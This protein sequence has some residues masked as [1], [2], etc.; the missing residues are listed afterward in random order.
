MN[1]Q[2][3]LTVEEYYKQAAEQGDVAAQISLGGN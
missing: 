1:K 3:G 2:T